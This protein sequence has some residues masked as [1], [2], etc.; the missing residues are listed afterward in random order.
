VPV[1]A[2]GQSPPQADSLSKKAPHY[3][4]RVMRTFFEVSVVLFVECL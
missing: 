2:R 1:T 4:V 3:P